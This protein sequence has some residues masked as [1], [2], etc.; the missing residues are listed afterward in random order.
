MRSPLALSVLLPPVVLLSALSP[1]ATDP[2]TSAT[3]IVVTA[4]D[5]SFDVPERV[6]AGLV[7]IR[8]V[9]RGET[10]HHAQLLR[11]DD[12]HTVADLRAALA[13]G[14]DP[15][16]AKLMGGPGV[17]LPGMEANASVVLRAGEYA[18]ICWLGVGEASHMAQGMVHGMTVEGA[19]GGELPRPTALIRLS[20]Y[21]F[22]IDPALSAGSHVIRVRNMA[23]QPHELVLVRLEPG[24][25]A[26]DL[27]AWLE[28]EEGPPPGMPIGGVVGL[29]QG[30]A[31]N[32]EVTLEPGAYALLC[33]VPD[34]TDDRP[35][36]MHG[37]AKTIMVE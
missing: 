18:W 5:F 16:W 23:S 35:H 1:S 9:N 3:E 14:E 32:I 36:F 17:I 25:T 30:E 33:F 4:T 7:T 22:A 34:R 28:T 20:D 26:E 27:L 8:L 10:M 29:A 37:M 21:D 13:A 24:R 12:G 11:L 6:E 2:T 15:A 19:G 31:N